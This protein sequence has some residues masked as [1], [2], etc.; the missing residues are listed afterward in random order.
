MRTLSGAVGWAVGGWAA[1]AALF[2]I[3][4]AYAGAWE[5]REMR[6]VH[7]LFLIPLAFLL[8]PARERSPR[9]RVTL[10]DWAWAAV[11]VVPCVYVLRYAQE[12]TER[13]EGVHPVT[14]GQVILGT[15]LVIAVLEA[16]RRSVGFWF[17]VTTLV[18][19]AYLVV[20]PWMPG[21]LR[22]PRAFTYPQL[23]EMFFLYADEGVLGSLTGISANLLMIFILFAAFMLHSGVGQ[24]FMDISVLMAGRYRGGPAKVAVVSSGLYG[25][26]SGSSVADCYAT[27][28]FSIP[29]MK[30]IGYKPEIAGAIEATASCGGPLMPPIMGAGAF[31]MAELTGV[32]YQEII[33]AAALPA[34]LYYL[35]ILATVH[36]EALKHGIGTMKAQLPPMTSLLRRALLFAPFVTVIYFLHAGYSPSKS[37]LYSLLTAI[38]VS[39]VAGDQP[40]TPR[41]IFA[42]M[43]DAMRSG[44][45]I[46]AV[47][48]ASGLIVAA[49]SR[50]GVALAFSS[51]VVNLSGGYLI[52]ALFLIFAIVSV[53]G[54]GIPTTPSYI[55]AVTVGG[56][57]LAKL[58][59]DIVAAHLFVFY[60]AVLADV[61]PPVAVTAVAAAQ[62]AHANPMTTG[63]QATRIGIG[64]F[65]A[66]F[67][68]VYQPALLM[69]GDWT[70]IVVSF[71]SAGIGISALCAALAGHMFTPLGWAARA[72]LTAVALSAISPSLLVSV[73]T[74][75]MIVA[76]G[77]WDWRRARS[78]PAP[79]PVSVTVAGEARIAAPPPTTLME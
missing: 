76:F 13:W 54:T 30:R 63:W 20:A 7:L 14:T 66:P 44:V 61:T 67:L 23:V 42:T 6:A 43:T 52:V 53:L 10:A 78:R 39:W 35:S 79:A 26:I 4:T 77:V 17:F 5:P 38:V 3:W 9:D 18:F 34:I 73:V 65:L 31:I 25:T 16:S 27:G 40:M 8:F 62:I 1:A 64:G 69:K 28:S 24:F 33:V 48:A 46:A 11:S 12:L 41:R 71:V 45:I 58:N 68:F 37:A 57:A 32:P 70:T 49:M 36:W 19:M 50:T 22:S 59:V 47:L 51:A 15:V 75:V 29:L 55:L 60:Y 72:V 56:A 74:S 21:F 2:H